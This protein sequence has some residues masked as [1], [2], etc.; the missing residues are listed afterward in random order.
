M[1]YLVI[2]S[3][4]NLSESLV[5]TSKMIVG[6]KER[7]FSIGLEPHGGSDNLIKKI[8]R[9]IST[10]EP[11]SQF[12][13]MIDLIGGTPCT[14]CAQILSCNKN[15]EIITGVNLPMLLE[16]Q[17]N[18]EKAKNVNEELF[19]GPIVFKWGIIDVRDKLNI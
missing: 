18:L 6:K 8:N 1:I 19:F 3:H 2:V 10:A 7:V 12:L 4:G 13:F 9:I 11:Q 17:L 14:S 16:V 5:A 15:I